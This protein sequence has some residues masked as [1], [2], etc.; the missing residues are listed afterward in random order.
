MIKNQIQQD[1]TGALKSGNQFLVGTLRMLL[2]SIITK[3]KE[4]R[5]KIIKEKPDATE[6]TL[7]KESE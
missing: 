6:E 4:L 3:E 7:S 2:A 1:S 5:Y